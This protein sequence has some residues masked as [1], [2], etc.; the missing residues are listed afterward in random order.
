MKKGHFFRSFIP[1]K[2]PDR[3][4]LTILRFL[5]FFSFIGKKTIKEHRDEN[6]R[7]L[8]TADFFMSEKAEGTSDKPRFIENQI[9]WGKVKFGKGKHGNMAYSGCEVIAIYNA[10]VALGASRTGDA[11]DKTEDPAK[12]MSSLIGSFE[13]KGSVRR[14]E[15][16]VA[17]TAIASFLKKKGY[18]I[19]IYGRKNLAEDDTADS[20]TGSSDK[21]KKVYIATIY[22]HSHDIF[23]QIHTVCITK[24]DNGYFIHNSYHKNADGAY[25][26]KPAS[27]EGYKTLAESIDNASSK[28]PKLLY[29]IEVM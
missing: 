24:E 1:Q 16:G 26:K 9:K 2:M 8:G 5:S 27:G 6:E 18:N 22:N 14:G 11:D 21:G 28:N 7:I 25:D 13:K 23:E 10:L 29:L 19:K 17:P 3:L 20:K 4:V 12:T 15:F